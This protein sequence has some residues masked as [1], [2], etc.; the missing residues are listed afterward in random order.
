MPRTLTMQKT[1]V[2]KLQNPATTIIKKFYTFSGFSS[3]GDPG[4]D[5]VT[6]QRQEISS[7]SRIQ[8]NTFSTILLQKLTES[9]DSPQR[10]I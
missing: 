1:R 3:F 4:R 10:H 6:S 7:K 2:K 5:L 8:V 9:T